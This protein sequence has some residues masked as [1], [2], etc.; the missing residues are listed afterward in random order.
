M[1]YFHLTKY[2]DYINL[3]KKI[4]KGISRSSLKLSLKSIGIKD[5]PFNL[6]V[7]QE[8]L[9]SLKMDNVKATDSC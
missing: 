8:A 6:K 4:I 7:A 2:T 5:V 9:D 3:F 1:H